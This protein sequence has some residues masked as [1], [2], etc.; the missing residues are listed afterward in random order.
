VRRIVTME[1]V[2]GIGDGVFWVGFVALLFR[3]DVGAPGFALAV[4]VRL[5]PRALLGA[6]AG[7]IADRFDRRR[8]LIWLDVGRGVCM[9]VLAVLVRWGAGQAM[10]LVVVFVAYALAAPYRPALT[11]G[12]PDVAGES[13]LSAANARIS[14]VRQV[15]TFVGPLLGAAVV[16]WSRLEYA[17]VLNAVTFAFAAVLVGSVPL[18][19]NRHEGALHRDGGSD[20]GWTSARAT[21][22]LAIVGALVL[23][24]YSIRGS[25]LVLYALVAE[26]RLGLGSAGVGLLA[27]AV[28]LGALAVMPLAPRLADSSRPDV[29]LTM[30]LLLNA[31]PIAALG[32]I[33]S[34]VVACLGLAVVGA[35]V[36]MFEVVSVVLLLRLA[37]RSSLGRV[38]GLIGSLSNGGK[39]LGAI[40][41]PVL[42][43]T[44]GVTG[45]LAVCGAFVAAAAI[46]SGPSLRG[47]RRTTAA[48]QARVRPIAAVLGSLPL[49]EGA[50]P[51]ALQ[52]LAAMAVEETCV[53]GAVVVRQG[54]I[55]DDLFVVRAGEFV[56]TVD[57]REVNQLGCDDWFGEIGLLQQRPR[58]ATVTARTDGTV[59]RVPGWVFLDALNDVATTPTALLDEMNRR[60][61]RL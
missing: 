59:W 41:A 55:A 4:V 47:L 38:F 23:V 28:G 9:V 37:D 25:E 15:M 42:V 45:A 36:V 34:P 7:A 32:A 49:F 17:F 20:G 12:L 30:S 14:T 3:L 24:M 56:A 40:A 35:G 44:A 60:L 19:S 57:S 39:L 27:G 22:G 50:S 52:R 33:R 54:A 16:Q 53:A 1:I 43:A 10:L 21:P 58:T 51:T 46:C 29:A 18:L 6:P 31:A 13:G 26:D 8:L 61:Q 11:A 5:A 48:E 2:S